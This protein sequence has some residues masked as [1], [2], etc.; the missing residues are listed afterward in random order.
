MSALK[1]RIPAKEMVSDLKA[2]LTD[3]AIIEKY[4]LSMDKF[5]SILKR[6][7]DAR[8]IS[9]KELEGREVWKLL[10]HEYKSM[11]AIPRHYVVVDL[12]I[13]DADDLLAEGFVRNIN[14]SGLKVAGLEVEIHSIKTLLIQADEFADVFPFVF[15][16]KCRWR[17]VDENG[18]PEVGFEITSISDESLVELNKLV[19]LLAFGEDD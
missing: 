18:D 19:E 4:H 11:R 12:P 5:R 6:L 17:R 10:T 1:R 9:E 8:A 2:G 16:A 14:R 13:Y 7:V 15:D 3:D